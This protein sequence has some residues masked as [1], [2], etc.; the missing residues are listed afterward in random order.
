MLTF[1]ELLHKPYEVL[2]HF[3]LFV[4]CV[5]ESME[6]FESLVSVVW[7][8]ASRCLKRQGSNPAVRAIPAN[9]FIH[10]VEKSL[11]FNGE[12]EPLIVFRPVEN[13]SAETV[14]C[15]FLA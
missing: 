6:P 15:L 4:Q 1:K 10:D 7:K 3:W 11:I 12:S 2:L 9:F 14:C 8:S 13:S 5:P